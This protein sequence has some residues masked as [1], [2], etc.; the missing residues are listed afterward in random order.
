[1]ETKKQWEIRNKTIGKEEQQM[2][3]SKYV[4]YQTEAHYHGRTSIEKS[5]KIDDIIWQRQRRH[6]HKNEKIRQSSTDTKNNIERTAYL[7]NGGTALK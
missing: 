3:A 5:E 7:W 6:R 1:M 2:G 4:Q